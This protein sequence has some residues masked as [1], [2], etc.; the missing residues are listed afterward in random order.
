MSNNTN[1][2]AAANTT[3][4]TTATRICWGT[5][6]TTDAAAST[7]RGEYSVLG[8]ARA[9]ATYAHTGSG[10][11]LY[12]QTVTFTA[13]GAATTCSAAVSSITLP[14]RLVTVL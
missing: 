4:N 2:P 11:T 6:T 9:L 12:T 3:S 7:S 14:S 1:A 10:T 13:T 5:D 8:F